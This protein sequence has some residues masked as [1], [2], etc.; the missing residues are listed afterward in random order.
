MN[1]SRVAKNEMHYV[2][3]QSN[4]VVIIDKFW[5]LFVFVFHNFVIFVIVIFALWALPR[6]CSL[7]SLLLLSIC[8]FVTVGFLFLPENV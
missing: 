5:F 4:K 1:G 2:C 8:R 3:F 6:C 7:S